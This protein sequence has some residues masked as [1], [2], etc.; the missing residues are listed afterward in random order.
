MKIPY[1]SEMPCSEA[2][3]NMILSEEVEQNCR[4]VYRPDDTDSEQYRI[5]GLWDPDAEYPEDCVALPVRSVLDGDGKYDVS[6]GT[7]FANVSE[8]THDKKVDNKSWIQLWKDVT[9]WQGKNKKDKPPCCAEPRICPND[10]SGDILFSCDANIVGG[11]V[12]LNQTVSPIAQKD[13]KY[14]IF[15]ICNTHNTYYYS[16]TGTG[17]HMITNRAITAVKLKDF[18]STKKIKAALEASK[19]EV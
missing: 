8:T 2:A 17:Y 16:G 15:P 3:A 1:L 18:F 5:Y 4:V 6:K 14:M 13:G 12:V 9:G 11:H 10:G 7:I 19:C